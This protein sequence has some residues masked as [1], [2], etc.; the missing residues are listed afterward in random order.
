MAGAGR[1]LFP[2][3]STLASADVQDYLMD[4]VVMRFSSAANRLAEVP[5]P[6]EGMFCTLDDTDALYRHDGT[7]WIRTE[8]GGWIQNVATDAS[9]IYTFAHGLGKT[10]RGVSAFASYQSTDAGSNVTVVKFWGCDATNISVRSYRTDTSAA[11]VTGSLSF[12]WS[13]HTL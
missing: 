13:A 8:N 9:A 6:T 1:K 2:E 12:I 10:P 7:A 11:Y 5:A 3:R 4:Q